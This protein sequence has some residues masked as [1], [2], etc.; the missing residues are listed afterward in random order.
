M[1]TSFDLPTRC[2]FS[3]VTAQEQGIEM[4]NM[5]QEHMNLDAQVKDLKAD[6][7][8]LHTYIH[9][10]KD[11]QDKEREE[12]T[13]NK[14]NA[15]TILGSFLLLPSFVLT[16]YSLEQ[17]EPSK[18]AQ[19]FTHYF[20]IMVGLLTLGGISWLLV[21][22]IGERAMDIPKEEKIQ[23]RAWLLRRLST[24]VIFGLVLLLFVV[25]ILLPFIFQNL[26]LS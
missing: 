10:L 20:V 2:I 8:Q 12:A 1:R 11:K 26:N 3:E 22:R 9:L 6:I 21:D 18:S 16:M 25:M 15:I 14:L 23:K 7:E 4:Y 13:T 5:L 24:W 17:Y 19:P